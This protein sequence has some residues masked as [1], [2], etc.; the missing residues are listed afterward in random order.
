MRATAMQIWRRR[1]F[2]AT[3]RLFATHVVGQYIRLL[4]LIQLIHVLLAAQNPASLE[5]AQTSH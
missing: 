4:W 3:D 5:R 1:C 2:W